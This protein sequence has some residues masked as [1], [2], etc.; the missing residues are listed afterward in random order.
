MAST[1]SRSS[2]TCGFKDRDER[3]DAIPVLLP[4]DTSNTKAQASYSSMHSGTMMTDVRHSH[5]PPPST[6]Y[7]VIALYMQRRKLTRCRVETELICAPAAHKK[8]ASSEW[9]RQ[10]YFRTFRNK[11]LVQ[12]KYEH[13]VY[14][15]S[16]SADVP[17]SE[18]G[19]AEI[20]SS[21]RKQ[22][23][24]QGCCCFFCASGD[25]HQSSSIQRS[26]SGGDSLSARAS[27]G[28]VTDARRKLFFFSE[29]V[30]HVATV[31]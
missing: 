7:N 9:C 17:E 6:S 11:T 30:P 4:S 20:S 1:P 8:S 28:A 5:L 10:A 14:W 12:N 23:G 25:K 26:L 16:D 2:P 24:W 19:L 29:T 31:H 21:R 27:V 13:E 22:S 18:G 15:N 3:Q